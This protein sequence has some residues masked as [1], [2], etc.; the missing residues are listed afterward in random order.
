M[1]CWAAIESWFRIERPG[2]YRGQ[3]NQICG[4]NHAFMPIEV[5]AVSKDA[6]KAWL[7]GAKNSL[8]M[9][10]APTRCASPWRQDRVALPARRLPG[11]EIKGVEG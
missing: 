7:V 8:H 5:R 10:A 1:R 6:F 4:I 9:T 2:V 11:I 3:C